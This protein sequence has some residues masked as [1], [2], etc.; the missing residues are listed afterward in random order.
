MPVVAIK[1]LLEAGVHF[2]HQTKRWNPKMGSYIYG[3]RNSVHIINLQKTVKKIEESYQF[4]KDL[5]SKGEIL[6]FVGTK[7]QSQESVEEEAKRCEMFYVTNRWLGGFLTNFETIKKRINRL[8]E[9]EE[10]KEKGMFEILPVKEVAKLEKEIIKLKKYFGGVKNMPKLPG[11]IFLTD[12]KKERTAMLEA[13]K[14][15]IP[16]IAIV[17]TNCDPDEADYIIPGN[18]DAVRAVKLISTIIANAA[19]EGRHG[20]QAIPKEEV[21]E[22]ASFEEEEKKIEE[23]SEE[24]EKKFAEDF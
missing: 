14:L 5:I 12:L 11:A 15:G 20:E 17:D 7:K 22:E 13:K 23:L 24:F 9:L 21:E 3:E 8:R 19:I 10:M 4:V 16:I 2:G 6:L 18:D 1:Q